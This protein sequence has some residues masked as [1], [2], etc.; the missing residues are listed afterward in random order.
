MAS[1]NQ[2]YLITCNT[3]PTGDVVNAFCLFDLSVRNGISITGMAFAVATGPTVSVI[4]CKK[5]LRKF[6]EEKDA[7]RKL[8]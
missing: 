5:F 3:G 8:R 6:M 7:A 1:I 4:K 2:W